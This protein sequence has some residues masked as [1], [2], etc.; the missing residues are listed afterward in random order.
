[1]CDASGVNVSNAASTLIASGLT[2]IDSTPAAV[3]AEDSGNANPDRAFRYDASLDG[4]IYNL[5]TKGLT[6]GTWA[7]TFTVNGDPVPHQVTFD[8]R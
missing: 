5:S 1:M 8:V 7:L 6:T 4:Y 3:P 2:K